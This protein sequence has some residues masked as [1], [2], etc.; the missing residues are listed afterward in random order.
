[1]SGIPSSSRRHRFMEQEL[2]NSAQKVSSGTSY[3]PSRRT[4]SSYETTEAAAAGKTSV[5]APSQRTDPNDGSVRRADQGQHRKSSAR[6][7]QPGK[8]LD[9]A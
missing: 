1:M 3:R 2:T 8:I 9:A 4:E 7:N 6:T 5:V